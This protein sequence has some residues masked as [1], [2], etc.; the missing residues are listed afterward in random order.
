MFWVIRWV[1]AGEDNAVVIEAETRAAAEYAALKRNIPVVI[2]GEADDGDVRAARKAKRLWKY[3]PDPT[4]T[5]LGRPVSGFH[6]LC[7]MMAGVL[8]AMLHVSRVLQA[9]S[10]LPTVQQ[11]VA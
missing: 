11:W 2:V 1:D 9:T 5:C 3:T 8:T 7:F 10:L 6:V 4:Y